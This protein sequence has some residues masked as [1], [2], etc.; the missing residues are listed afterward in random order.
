[1][2]RI[3]AGSWTGDLNRLTGDRG[4]RRCVGAVGS[5]GARTRTVHEHVLLAGR[6]A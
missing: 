5:Y 3:S 4:G 6:C 1:M 2:P